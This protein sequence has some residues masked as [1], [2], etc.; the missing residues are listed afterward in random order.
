LCTGFLLP[1]LEVD[2]NYRS[3]G[4]ILCALLLHGSPCFAREEVITPDLA[5]LHDPKIWRV[6]NANSEVAKED[7]QPIVRLAPKGLARTPSDIGLAVVEGVEF[8]EGTLEVDLKGAGKEQRI[9]L[10]VA[11]AIADGKTFEAVYFRPFNFVAESDV[12][13]ARAVQ[14]VAWPEHTWEKL[15][16]GKPGVYEAAI[17]PVPD[18]AGWFHARIEVSKKQVRV[19]VGDGKKP[20]LVV[21]RLA[22]REKGKVGLW[23]DSQEGTFRNL[24]ILKARQHRVT[25]QEAQTYFG[26]QKWAEAAAAYEQVVGVNPNDGRHWLSYGLCLH[27]LKRY[28]DA[29]KAWTRSIELGFRP[30]TG[31]YNLACANA[32]AGRKD[33][34]LDWLGK[35][36]EAGFNQ[37]EFLR[38]DSDLDSLRSDA[39]F[40]KLLGTAP[41]GLTREERWR[42]DLDYLVRRMEKVHYNLYAKVSRERF[43]ESVNELKGRVNTLKDEGMAVGIQRI[44]ALVGDG[45]THL[46]FRTRPDQLLL[47]YPVELFLFKEGLCVRAA[48]KEYSDLVGGKVLR[49]GTAGTED[50][51]AAVA[52][53]CSRDNDMGVKLQSP[54]LLTNPAVLSYLKI[55]SDMTG[56]AIV[57]QK[58]DGEQ[59]T[60]NLK[61]VMVGPEKMK[62]FVKA[63]RNASLPE[64]LSFKNNEDSFWFEHVPERKLVY[65]Q[66]NAVANK[67]NET[68]EKFCTRLFRF[69]NDKEVENL[70]IDMRNNGGGNNFLNRALI[71][72]LIRCDRV[73]R[74]RHLYVLVGRR[75]FSAAMNCSVD[76]ERNTN[77]IF[78]G[79]PTGSSPNFVGE[80]TIL[81]LPC[82]GLRFSCSSLYWQSSTATD[83]RTWI[84]PELV[85]EPSLVAFASN[86]DPGLEAIFADLN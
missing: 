39:R 23:V 27:S 54:I 4:W 9:F 7:D 51:L 70:V 20:C 58:P 52:P 72:G 32:L 68:L 63:N 74:P 29:I 26:Q 25:A 48:A 33:E 34:S 62:G 66:F 65:F 50:A 84:A 17:D 55:A 41:E 6:I 8:G 10:G 35:A 22:N 16:E 21:E 28:D 78:V 73:N 19:F 37:E 45:H 14:Y 56:V 47:R 11:F 67:P 15:R 2:M 76:L 36:L 42:F 71:H 69:I 64:P 77:A 79:E 24:T 80:T 5:R 1:G 59:V 83:R 44:L 75:T 53:L 18:P 38:T 57:V 61:P 86:R 3:C 82:S 40:K 60:A 46:M 85:A 13:R 43:Q 30:E 81:R 49:I 31:L 12:Y